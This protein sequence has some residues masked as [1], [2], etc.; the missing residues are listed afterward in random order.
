MNSVNIRT[1]MMT[2][3]D[4]QL[5][6]LDAQSAKQAIASVA[7]L[8]E[9]HGIDWALVGGVALSLYGSDRL[10]KDIDAIASELLPVPR[11]QVAGQL[12]QGGERYNTPTEKRSVSVDWIVRKDEFKGLF[13]QALKEA[14]MTDGVPVLTPEWLVI[15]KFIAGRFKDQEDAVFLLSRKGLVDRKLIQE[16]IVKLFGRAAWGLAKHGYE[17]WYDIAD[18]K[19]RSEAEAEGYIDS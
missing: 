5:K 15:L 1:T 13:Q 18:G 3:D 16:K 9:E 7:R 8:A 2:I 14:V 17:R 11:S 4:L 12:R 10:T 6:F 19:S